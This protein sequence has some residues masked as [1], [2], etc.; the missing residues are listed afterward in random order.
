MYAF[1][2]LETVPQM[3]GHVFA[4]LAHI[5]PN[6]NATK[7]TAGTSQPKLWTQQL[8]LGRRAAHV[9]RKATQRQQWLL[10]RFLN[11]TASKFWK[12]GGISLATT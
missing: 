3:D 7:C 2:A 10:Q 11:F 4:E 8:G 12:G 5:P 9:R 6:M 1:S